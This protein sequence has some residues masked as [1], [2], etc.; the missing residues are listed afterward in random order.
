MKKDIEYRI[1]RMTEADLAGV[2]AVERASFAD[3]WSERS[4]R[5][6]LALPYAFYYLAE[7]DGRVLGTAGLQVIA[8][9]GEISNVAVL[10]AFR[11]LGIAGKILETLLREGEEA[12]IG[13]FTLEVRA[14]NR[15]AIALYEGLGFREEGRRPRF[16]E[17]PREDALILWKRNEK[18]L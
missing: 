4:Y 13:A 18:N 12:G 8:G 16:Y 10:P 3:P 15:P 5:E 1:R 9:E 2:L 6:T 7:A 14:G 11:G 17:N